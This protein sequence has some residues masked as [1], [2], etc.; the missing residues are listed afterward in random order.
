MK[1]HYQNRLPHV[2]PIGAT[3]FVTFRQADSLPQSTVKQLKLEL[4]TELQKIE[5]LNPPD[6]DL[7]I[8]HAKK[9]S[10]GQYEHQLDFNPYGSCHLRNPEV[11]RILIERVREYHGK[12]I[13]FQALCVMP[14][15]VHLLF[16]MTP[17]LICSQE[18]H[19]REIPESYVQLDYL[20]Q[21]IK[22]GASRR[23]NQFLG[24]KKT[25]WAKDSYDHYVRNEKEWLR[26]LNYILQ[27]PVKARLVSNWEEW[28]YTIVEAEP[29]EFYKQASL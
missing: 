15:H 27:N 4:R 19:G 22:G 25:F 17:Q 2:A 21:L 13:D 1:I 14:N 5:Q 6:K 23:I 28:P 18:E 24:T 16:S 26:I 20:M 11:A 8:V 29:L 7:Q 9:R 3:F 12:L 10:F